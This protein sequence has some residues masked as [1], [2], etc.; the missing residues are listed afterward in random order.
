MKVFK[1]AD[2]YGND[3]SEKLFSAGKHYGVMSSNH[4][5]IKN[6]VCRILESYGF[7][8]DDEYTVA[9]G[10]ID[11]IGFRSGSSKPFL[12]IEVHV[13]GDL[14]T[15]LKKLLNSPFL[16]NRIIITPDRPL[17][18]RMSKSM[19]DIFW[20]P[21]PGEDDHSFEDYVRNLPGAATRS[22]YWHQAKR[23]V[24]ILEAN[25]KAAEFEESLRR[26]DPNVD[27]G[28]AEEIIYRF[29][30]AGQG[31]F[32]DSERYKDTNEYKLLSSL[33]IAQG[34]K[35]YL[36]DMEWGDMVKYSYETAEVPMITG[37]G[38]MK[39]DPLAYAE[40]KEIIR[41]V[42][43]RYIE[44]IK[45]NIGGKIAGYSGIFSEAALTG[46][47][48]QFRPYRNDSF[49]AYAIPN[50]RPPVEVARLT[51]LV[52]N[53][54]L[55]K[56]LWEFGKK[57]SA[58]GLG[59]KV[60]DD[61]ILAPY[62]PIAKIFGFSGS[63]GE[64]EEEIGEYLAWW[65]LYRGGKRDE[66]IG[67][68]CDILGIPL[69]DVIKCIDKTSSMG[70]TSRYIDGTNLTAQ[71]RFLSSNGGHKIGGVSNIAVFRPEEFEAYCSKKMA[72]SLT[73]IFGPL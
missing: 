49:S 68:H 37:T 27:V 24:R 17:I 63:S 10:R 2:S 65:T 20:C 56:K 44:N 34:L 53:P 12:G 62:K 57:L 73:N 47:A 36:F 19:P 15:D 51:A 31:S 59:V 71:N 60:S 32:K 9:D 6:D 58:T 3:L 29:A 61:L 13:Q 67:Q 1:L 54:F 43:A 18:D 69:E 21:P 45:I 42:V 40:N 35:V 72:E 16:S 26:Y 55:S 22:M 46:T 25:G 50:W 8:C 66:D 33:G 39:G 28:L 64:K 14:D 5:S 70:I 52:A 23:M 30:T 11:C 7:Q 41:A 4:E 38:K 48:G